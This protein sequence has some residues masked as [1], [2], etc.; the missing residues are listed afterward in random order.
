MQTQQPINLAD[1]EITLGDVIRKIKD[2]L[3]EARRLWWVILLFVIPITAIFTFLALT[4]EPKFK[5]KLSFM[6]NSDEGGG[7][8]MDGILGAIAAGGIKNADKSMIKMIDLMKSRKITT[9]TLFKRAVI[10]GKEDY[11]ANHY[12]RL[13]DLEE[14]WQASKNFRLKDFYFR[15]D[16]N[17]ETFSTLENAVLITIY[18]TIVNKN[19][20][21]ESGESGIIE[22]MFESQS[23]AFTFEFINTLFEVLSQFYI[24][25]SVDKQRFAFELVSQRA[26]TTEKQLYEVEFQLADF[27]DSN[28]G[29]FKAT[30]FLDE[31]RLRR[32]MEMLSAIYVESIKSREMARMALQNRTPFISVIDAPIYP[33]PSKRPSL[34]VN[35][36]VGLALGT[37]FGFLFVSV[38]K[39]ILDALRYDQA[40]QLARTNA[41]P[42]DIA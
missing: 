25:R 26:D 8:M 37:F 3:D 39:V 17:P 16:S 40:R 41:A 22:M 11:L 21:Y 20:T 10:D 4:T 28:H 31:V 36:I 19:L 2:F 34:P 15:E 1:D 30:S 6:L 32:E 24:E 33:L 27:R 13:F 18:N 42:T 23:E 38:R 35:I 29:I 5:A 9:A 14:E 12:I 7:F